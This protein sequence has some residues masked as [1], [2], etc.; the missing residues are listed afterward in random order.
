M[1]VFMWN[2]SFMPVVH[3]ASRPTHFLTLPGS[4]AACVSLPRALYTCIL[5]DIDWICVV[6]WTSVPPPVGFSQPVVGIFPAVFV[7]VSVYQSAFFRLALGGQ[8]PA[9]PMMCLG[10]LFPGQPGYQILSQRLLAGASFCLHFS[11]L[12]E[13]VGCSKQDGS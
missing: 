5:K 10:N 3:E 7:C 11:Y 2:E 9:F 4:Q 12:F 6:A 1:P 13:D 8:P